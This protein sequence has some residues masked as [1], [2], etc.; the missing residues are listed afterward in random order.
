LKHSDDI[1]RTGVVKHSALN[2]AATV[3]IGFID[4]PYSYEFHGYMNWYI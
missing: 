2:T 3:D 1:E 4:S